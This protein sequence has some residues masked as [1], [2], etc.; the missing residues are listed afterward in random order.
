MVG[1]AIVEAGVVVAE[2][3]HVIAG[4]DHAESP[5]SKR[6][7]VSSEDAS[8]TLHSN[9]VAPA[10]TGACATLMGAGFARVVIGAK[11]PS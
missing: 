7:V 11:D 2:G 3:W 9:P 8:I 5:P 10:G 4:Q 6:L 1:A